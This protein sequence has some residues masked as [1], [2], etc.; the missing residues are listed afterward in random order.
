MQKVRLENFRTICNLKKIRSYSYQL[1]LPDDLRSIHPIF[2]TSLLR[3]DP[4]NPISGQVNEPNPPIKVDKSGED[5]YKVDAIVGSRRLKQ[6]GFQYRVK[7]TRQYETLW[8]SLYDI[9]SGDSNNLVQAFHKSNP[10]GISPTEKEYAEAIADAN[11][12]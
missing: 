9:V 4:N 8:Q 10:R 11:L 12:G 1:H 7:Y 6:K 2:H 3:P 5:L